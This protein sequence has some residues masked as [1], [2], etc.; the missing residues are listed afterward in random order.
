M[1]HLR[2]QGVEKRRWPGRTLPAEQ[3]EEAGRLYQTGLNLEAVAE[4]FDVD[5]R[6]VRKALPAAGF[7]I[8]RPGQRKRT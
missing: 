2:R 7:P 8:R 5:R 6:Y 1:E 4:R 3:V